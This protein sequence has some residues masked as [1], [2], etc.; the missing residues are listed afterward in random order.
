MQNQEFKKDLTKEC[1]KYGVKIPENANFQKFVSKKVSHNYFV[2]TSTHF[3]Y[4]WGQNNK[5]Y[6]WLS[7]DWSGKGNAEEKRQWLELELL[8]KYNFPGGC[9]FRDVL[10][11]A[12]ELEAPFSKDELREFYK[13]GCKKY[14]YGYWFSEEHYGATLKNNDLYA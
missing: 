3:S 12:E 5:G 13:G 14:T 8:L 6:I 1:Q 9:Y 11:F 7:F 2:E 10:G 4:V